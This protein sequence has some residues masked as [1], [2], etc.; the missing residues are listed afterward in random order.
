MEEENRIH[1][2]YG[3]DTTLSNQ[4]KVVSGVPRVSGKKKCQCHEYEIEGQPPYNVTVW[5]P[6]ECKHTATLKLL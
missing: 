6:T 3:H 4:F 1:R 2:G 5:L